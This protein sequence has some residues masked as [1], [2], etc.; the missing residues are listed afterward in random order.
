[1][2]LQNSILSWRCLLDRKHY[3]LLQIFKQF[4]IFKTLIIFSQAIKTPIGQIIN[5]SILGKTIEVVF[6]HYKN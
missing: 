2:S 4:I 1:M 6:I 3:E 5:N